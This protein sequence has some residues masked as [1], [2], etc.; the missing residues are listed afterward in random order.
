M[1]KIIQCLAFTR[2]I[3]NTL[4]IDEETCERWTTYAKNWGV[5]NLDGTPLIVT[6]ELVEDN[7]GGI[8]VKVKGRYGVM[9][10]YDALYEMA[11]EDFDAELWNHQFDSSAEGLD[12]WNE[13]EWTV[14][15]S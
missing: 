12:D 15:N 5:T 4:N 6:P 2:R 8:G 14:E 1:F 13:E 11:E 9:P 10:L 3:E 7:W